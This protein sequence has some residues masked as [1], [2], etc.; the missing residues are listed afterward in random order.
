[1]ESIAHLAFLAKHN[2]KRAEKTR[3]VLERLVGKPSQK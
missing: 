1:M 2:A 3:G